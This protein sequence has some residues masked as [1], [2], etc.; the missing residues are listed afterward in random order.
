MLDELKRQGFRSGLIV[1]DNKDLLSFLAHHFS[2]FLNVVTATNGKDALKQIEQSNPD[3][4]V[5]DV[6]MPEMD[7]FELCQTIKDRFETCH[8]P[9]VLLTAK[10]GSDSKLEG[11]DVGADGYINKPFHLRELE[12]TVRNILR[13]KQNIRN[14][15]LNPGDLKE[16][17]QIAGLNIKDQLF[18]EKLGKIIFDDLENPDLTVEFLCDKMFIS[19]T[20]LHMK[21]KKITGL[22]TSEYVRNIK[23]NEAKIMLEK[24]LYTVSEVA[25]KVGFN[26]PSYFSKTFKHFFNVP[27]STIGKSH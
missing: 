26:D 27:P 7:G 22:S 9:F 6:M 24:G 11:L 15:F 14:S 19:R 21:M 16:N 8:I 13:S 4:V 12:L 5:S 2:H 18:L 17:K 3:V 1:E 20:L 23:L 10:S 25:F